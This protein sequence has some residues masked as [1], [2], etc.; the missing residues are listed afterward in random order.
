M[1]G[2]PEMPKTSG[3]L[4]GAAAAAFK[5]VGACVTFVGCI[6]ALWLMP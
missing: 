5:A 2:A 3:F 6:I 1:M 4:F